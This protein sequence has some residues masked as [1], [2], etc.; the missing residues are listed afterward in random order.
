MNDQITLR[1][2]GHLTAE[3]SISTCPPGTP[4]RGKNDPAPLPKMTVGG[5]LTPYFPGGGLRGTMR[6]RAV[7]LVRATLM[8][9]SGTSPFSLDDHYYLVL[10]GVKGDDKEDKADIVNSE[11]RR[12]ANPIIG[13]F[14]AGDPWQQGRLYVSHAIPSSSTV[15]VEAVRGARVDDFARS[16]DNLRVLSPDEQQEW[17]KIARINALRS[18][19]AKEQTTVAAKLKDKK[20]VEDERKALDAQYKA[21]EAEIEAF[22]KESGYTNAIN[23]PLDGYEIIPQFTQMQ[24]SLTLSFANEN[25]IGLLISTLRFWA[26]DPWIGAHRSHGCGVVSGNWDVS[27]RVGHGRSYDSIGSVTMAAFEGVTAPDMLME[28][29]EKFLSALRK[30]EGFE[31]KYPVKAA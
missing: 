10:G 21:L 2:N 28:A 3:T 23:R 20:T 9:S 25:E 14:G 5:T 13:L 11:A 26:L 30:N 15:E 7:D 31:F 6:R 22:G 8:E 27:M 24:H 29:E 16:G 19:K 12:K 1:F 17:L 18:A 4:K